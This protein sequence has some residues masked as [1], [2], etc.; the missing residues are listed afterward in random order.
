VT[1]DHHR[2]HG[3]NVPARPAAVGHPRGRRRRRAGA[4]PPQ[5]SRA[6]PTKLKTVV[7]PRSR[8]TGARYRSRMKAR[9]EAEAD[10][11]SSM[12]RRTRWGEVDDHAEG[13]DTFGRAGK[14]RGCT[15]AVLADDRA[16]AGD[17]EGTECG[18]IDRAATV[19]ARTAV[20]RPRRGPR[21]SA[22]A[23]SRA[24]GRSSPPRSHLVRK[25]ATKAA[26]WAGSLCPGARRRGCEASSAVR[27]CRLKTL[28]RPPAIR[29][30][31]SSVSPSPSSPTRGGGSSTP[32]AAMMVQLDLRRLSSISRGRGSTFPLASLGTASHSAVTLGGVEV[33]P[34]RLPRR[35]SPFVL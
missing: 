26:I 11:A 2:V 5:D 21:G 32:R 20:S 4:W 6:G 1:E 13:F 24:Q 35:L 27:S 30:M 3:P 22:W 8:R 31:V 12:H 19:P 15:P 28:P 9:S 16:C 34:G 25:P 14:R 17:H 33:H 7:T 18:D 23:A 10:P 29:R